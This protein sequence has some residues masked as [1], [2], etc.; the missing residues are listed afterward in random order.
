MIFHLYTLKFQSEFVKRTKFYIFKAQSAAVAPSWSKNNGLVSLLKG[1]K[2]CQSGVGLGNRPITDCRYNPNWNP[3]SKGGQAMGGV[4]VRHQSPRHRVTI[5]DFAPG[6]TTS[7]GK[8]KIIHCSCTV[9]N[10]RL[11]QI[12]DFKF[13]P[14]NHKPFIQKLILYFLIYTRIQN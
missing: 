3:N 12:S 2:N 13:H 11:L 6:E 14:F 1:R 4:W 8:M 9:H 7:A 10:F 5:F